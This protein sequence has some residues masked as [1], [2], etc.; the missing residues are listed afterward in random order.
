MLDN[1]HHELLKGMENEKWD[2]LVLKAV[3]AAE[4]SLEIRI[5]DHGYSSSTTHIICF[6]SLIFLSYEE[7][8][9]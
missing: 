4:K 7:Q 5:T 8:R 1:Q 2:L 6:K 9:R 3:K